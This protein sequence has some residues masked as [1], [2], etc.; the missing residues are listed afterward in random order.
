[1][2]DEGTT[3]HRT[4]GGADRI[5]RVD[6]RGGPHCADGWIPHRNRPRPGIGAV[7]DRVLRRRL[8]APCR[9][10]AAVALPDTRC[11]PVCRRGDCRRAPRH[12]NR[13]RSRRGDDGGRR[14]V[15]RA[16]GG[17]RGSIRLR[18]SGAALGGRQ[19]CPVPN[20]ARVSR[21]PGPTPSARSVRSAIGRRTSAA[22]SCRRTR[23]VCRCRWRSWRGCLA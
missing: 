13:P 7:A 14:G 20:A 22:S 18:E 21:R 5:R 12:G 17:R 1:M 9:R 2:R 10:L 15:R 19:S 3:I 4:A 8:A 6:G 16:R 11:S 23:R